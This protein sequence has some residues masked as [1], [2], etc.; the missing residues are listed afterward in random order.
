[1]DQPSVARQER[2]GL[3]AGSMSDAFGAASDCRRAKPLPSPG[4]GSCARH[5][6]RK[7]PG[8]NRWWSYCAPSWHHSLSVLPLA[9][10]NEWLI[11]PGARRFPTPAGRSNRIRGHFRLPCGISSFMKRLS[12]TALFVASTIVPARSGI[13]SCAPSHADEALGRAPARTGVARDVQ[14]AL[15]PRRWRRHARRDCRSRTGD[16]QPH[17]A[18]AS[19]RR[20]QAASQLDRWPRPSNFSLPRCILKACTIP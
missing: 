15:H 8:R 10:R 16:V 18:T 2:L 12:P 14:R 11:R 6:L 4:E 1:L 9:C 3:N 17:A 20:R 5:G 7:C 13:A 19:C